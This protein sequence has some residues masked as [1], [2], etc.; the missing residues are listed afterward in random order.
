MIELCFC[1]YLT[2]AISLDWISQIIVSI[3]FVTL[4][5]VKL[6]LFYGFSFFVLQPI[7]FFPT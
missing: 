7:L 5:L 4:D 3:A 6:P 1:W 2:S